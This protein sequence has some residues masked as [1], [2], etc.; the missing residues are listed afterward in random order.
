MIKI[1]SAII[2]CGGRGS[3]LGNLG[4]K[5]PKTLVK[6]HNKPILWYIVKALKK[7][8]INHFILPLGYKGNQIR[9]YIKNDKDLKKLN[10]DLINTGLNTSISKRIF[11]VK[12]NIKSDHIILLNGDAIF[13]FNLNLNLMNLAC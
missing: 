8:S 11:S 13:D 5:I 12:E 4:K 3:R 9:K 1:K 10:F 7:N 2:L 6:I